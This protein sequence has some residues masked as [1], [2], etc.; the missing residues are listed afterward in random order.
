[1]TKPP[2]G[3][4]VTLVVSV[5][6]TGFVSLANSRSF[7]P[8]R[9]TVAAQDPSFKNERSTRTEFGSAR[10]LMPPRY[11]TSRFRRATTIDRP[12]SPEIARVSSHTLGTFCRNVF[13]GSGSAR[14]DCVLSAKCSP[15]DS[16]TI[17]RASSW[18]LVV[19]WGYFA[20]PNVTGV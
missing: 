2:R 8:S 20:S 13:A 4:I 15:P 17:D 7:A 10:P 14:Y 9:T 11:Q 18:A 6:D 19:L 5:G 12:G 16:N 1:M 3:R